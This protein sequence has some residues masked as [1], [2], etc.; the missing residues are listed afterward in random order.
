MHLFDHNFDHDYYFKLLLIKRS[1]MPNQLLDVGLHTIAIS[2]LSC[3]EPN[4]LI[5]SYSHPWR[6]IQNKRIAGFLAMATF[7][8]FH[9]RRISR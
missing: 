6:I 9:P 3:V 8:I 7:A 5:C 1:R 2:G 4:C